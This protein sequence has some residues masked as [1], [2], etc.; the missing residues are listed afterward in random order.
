MI[1][2]SSALIPFLR[3]DSTPQ[4]ELLEHYESDRIPYAIPAVCAQEVLQGAADEREWKLLKDYLSVQQLAY[5]EQSISTHL[6]A[7]RIYFDARRKGIILRSTIDCLIAQLALERK[8][9]LLHADKDF[10]RIA[11]IRPLKF[12]KMAK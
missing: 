11:E 12:V 6:K 9:S 3:G 4:V 7:A 5:P 8:E 1:V 10:E 2:D